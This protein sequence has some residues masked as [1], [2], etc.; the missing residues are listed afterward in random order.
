[1]LQQAMEAQFFMNIRKYLFLPAVL[2]LKHAME[3]ALFWFEKPLIVDS[4]IKLLDDWC[5]INIC[6]NEI[7]DCIPVFFCWIFTQCNP[8]ATDSDFFQTVKL[9]N[10]KNPETPYIEDPA[11]PVSKDF[12][13][14]PLILMEMSTAG[15]RAKRHVDIRSLTKHILNRA[16]YYGVTYCKSDDYTIYDP[17]N[18]LQ[19][20]ET[21]PISR[22]TDDQ[23]QELY[24]TMAKKYPS[25]SL[26][27]R[28]ALNSDVHDQLVLLQDRTVALL[29][30]RKDSNQRATSSISDDPNSTIHFFELFN[31]LQYIVGSKKYITANDLYQ[32]D[33]KGTRDAT[34]PAHILSNLQTEVDTDNVYDIRAN[35]PVQQIT[36]VLL[37][38]S[39]S[40]FENTVMLDSNDSK[41]LID[42]SIIMLGIL[43]DNIV[44]GQHAHAFGLIHFGSSV[45]DICPITRSRDGFENALAKPPEKQEWTCMYVAISR[46]ITLMINYE[47]NPQA[48][49]AT[50]CK[51]LIIC[52]SDGIENHSTVTLNQ[53]QDRIKKYNVVIDFVSFLR[54]TMIK[55]TDRN[56]VKEFMKL[57]RETHGYIYQ[58]LPV[59]NIELGA[60]FEQEAALRICDRD[61]TKYGIVEKPVRQMPAQLHYTA[62]EKVAS[63]FSQDIQGA[64]YYDRV[65][66]EIKNVLAA[67]LEDFIVFVCQN[68]I[69][70]WKIILKGP[71][72]TPYESGHWVLYIHFGPQYPRH[73]PNVRFLTEIYHVNVSGDGKVCHHIFDRGWSSK[74]TMLE[75]FECIFDL[76]K[77]PNFDDAVSTEK[78]QLK[79]DDPNKYNLQ[80][81]QCTQR[82][83]SENIQ[84]LKEK[85]QLEN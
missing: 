75:I 34:L 7:C 45:E 32:V 65:L 38:R 84:K 42:M 70:F 61:P 53:L 23:I 55:E 43:S 51:K 46:A 33:T 69:F 15:V 31:P 26:I 4:L 29:F 41:T 17:P 85:F 11:T 6:R 14:G 71:F 48:R 79:R 54:D 44:Y 68:D 30:K 3:G 18:Q 57:C 81:K 74:T 24:E 66:R 59:S 56:T 2:A 20:F 82:H 50:N 60:T 25:F 83:A 47:R 13:D 39:K 64:P 73:P 12:K 77:E 72:G 76:L 19:L 27:T 10:L 8:N 21:T 67:K 62:T 9:R 49:V 80:A 36:V 37:D 40:M 16:N 5:P 78:A 58:N 52:I 28:S 1:M 63:R 22:F 35:V